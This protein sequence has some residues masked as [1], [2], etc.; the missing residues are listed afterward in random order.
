MSPKQKQI[1]A[2]PE[3]GGKPGEGA[4]GGQVQKILV[5]EAGETLDKV[6]ELLA[7]RVREF[8]PLT[9][10]GILPC[11]GR[12]PGCYKC[13]LCMD[14]ITGAGCGHSDSRHDNR[15]GLGGKV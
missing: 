1:P 4:F 3:E 9:C 7:D 11:K 5:P 13:P 14:C 15:T 6:N 8:A 12:K 10:C 2:P